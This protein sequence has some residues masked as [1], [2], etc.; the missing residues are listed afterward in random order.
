[1]ATKVGMEKNFIRWQ[2]DPEILCLLTS[3]PV[4]DSFPVSDYM[5]QSQHFTSGAHGPSQG[6]VDQ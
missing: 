4:P 1:M 3:L 6:N 2:S 5:H